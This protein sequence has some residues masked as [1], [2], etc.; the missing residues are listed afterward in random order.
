VVEKALAALPGGIAKI[1]LRGN[2]ALYE[3]ELMGWLDERR[4]AMRSWPT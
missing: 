1:Y 2:S 3:H 4:S